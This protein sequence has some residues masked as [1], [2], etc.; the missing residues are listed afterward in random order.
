MGLYSGAY[1]PALVFKAP[2]TFPPVRKE[3][4]LAAS[5]SYNGGDGY[6]WMI[7]DL[8][9]RSSKSKRASTMLEV[10]YDA[11]DDDPPGTPAGTMPTSTTDINGK[12]ARASCAKHRCSIY[13]DTL[14]T[15]FTGS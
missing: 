10:I 15:L 12:L 1:S 13:N 6:K 9:R 4:S 14:L 11:R 7:T 8:F 2:D 3:Y 5:L